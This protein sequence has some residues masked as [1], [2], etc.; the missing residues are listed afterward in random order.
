MTHSKSESTHHEKDSFST[1]VERHARKGI[2]TAALFIGASA[3]AACTPTEANE[4]TETL[5]TTVEQ[6]VNP[7]APTPET[8]PTQ[9]LKSWEAIIENINPAD[10]TIQADD[11]LTA[12]QLAHRLI[13]RQNSIIEMF[14][15][16]EGAEALNDWFDDEFENG[17]LNPKISIF[18]TQ[19]MNRA[20]DKLRDTYYATTVPVDTEADN[21]SLTYIANELGN[22]LYALYC[23]GVAN[24]NVELKVKTSI[25]ASE[26]NRLDDGTYTVGVRVSTETNSQEINPNAGYYKLEKFTFHLINED[27]EI[28]VISLTRDLLS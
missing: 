14:M 11:T 2:A 9:Q 26:M 12:E 22:E 27:G 7:T 13:D 23:A 16:Q 5:T 20:V 6:P 17:N 24:Y 25:Q 21:F 28:R 1:I 3:L 10:Y 4:P 18:A 19:Q 15:N 8:T